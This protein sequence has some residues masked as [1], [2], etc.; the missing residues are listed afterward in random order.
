MPDQGENYRLIG[1]IRRREESNLARPETSEFLEL[2]Q[3]Q[4][5][6]KLSELMEQG[7]CNFVPEKSYRLNDSGEIEEHEAC[8]HVCVNPNAN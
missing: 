7:K 1:P 6:S 5:R 2:V 3:Q 8:Y 4:W